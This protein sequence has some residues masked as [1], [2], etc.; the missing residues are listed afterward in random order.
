MKLS[1]PADAPIAPR[2]GSGSGH[3]RG[4]ARVEVDRELSWTA[5][6]IEAAI[7]SLPQTDV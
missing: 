1:P 2:C 5:K 6:E 4:R 3:S 7:E